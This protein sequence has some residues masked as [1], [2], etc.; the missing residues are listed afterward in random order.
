MEAQVPPPT[1][2][3]LVAEFIKKR[4]DDIVNKYVQDGGWEP[5]FQSE[6]L[7]FIK[8][9][10][11]E[12]QRYSGREELI[13]DKPHDKDKV[14]ILTFYMIGKESFVEAIE[15]K[16]ASTRQDYHE[17]DL[18]RRMKEDI[19]KLRDGMPFVKKFVLADQKRFYAVS[20]GIALDPVSAAYTEN[21]LTGLLGN[22]WSSFSW[23]PG[24]GSK[25][26]ITAFTYWGH[27]DS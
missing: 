5:W 10:A 14:D 21:T 18:G 11:G 8:I 23:I 19:K 1:A 27:A 22:K 16:C 6:F 15:F 17:T 2:M 3:N 25:R 20:I 13:W 9:Q 4:Y 7:D 24:D 12:N 26:T